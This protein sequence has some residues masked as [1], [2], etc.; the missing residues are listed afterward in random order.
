MNNTLAP[1][2]KELLEDLCH[3][4]RVEPKLVEELI[5]IEK[6]SQHMERRVGIY[7]ALSVGS[8]NLFV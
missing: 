8:L 5:K 4:Y 3:K 1:A 6:R 2:E 7:D